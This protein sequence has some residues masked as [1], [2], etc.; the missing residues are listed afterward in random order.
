MNQ[1]CPALNKDDWS[2]HEDAILI[3]RQRSFGNV[4]SRIAQFLPGRSSNAVKNRWSWLSRHAAAPPMPHRGETVVMVAAPSRP[5]TLWDDGRQEMTEPP[6]FEWGERPIG[7]SE[8]RG[9]FSEQGKGGRSEV[10]ARMAESSEEPETGIANLFHDPRTQP[11]IED[12]KEEL[13]RRFEHW[14]F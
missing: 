7:F 1:L 3:Q 6:E 8:K 14:S 12:D 10:I 11:E 4:W 9:T 2:P 13:M 5:G